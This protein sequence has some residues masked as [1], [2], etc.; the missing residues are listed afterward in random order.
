MSYALADKSA[1]TRSFATYNLGRA[2]VRIVGPMIVTF[3]VIEQGQ[4]GWLFLGA[5]LLLAGLGMSLGTRF[6]SE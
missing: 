6:L 2:A 4:I 3:V 5:A 1:L